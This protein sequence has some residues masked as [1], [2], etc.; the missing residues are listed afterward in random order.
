[1][2][3]ENVAFHVERLKGKS[4]MKQDKHPKVH[5]NVLT[6]RSGV[7]NENLHSLL[8]SESDLGSNYASASVSVFKVLMVQL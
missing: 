2:T 3:D 6:N 1:M 5:L 8:S 7:T 4:Q